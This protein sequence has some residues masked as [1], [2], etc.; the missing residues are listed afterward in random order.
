MKNEPYV[1][2]APLK[3]DPVLR[4]ERGWLDDLANDEHICFSL[5][6]ERYFLFPLGYHKYGFCTWKEASEG[7]G[8]PTHVFHS[9]DEVLDAK[10]FN[11]RSIRERL[12]EILVYDQA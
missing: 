4:T 9:E 11:G 5:D 12:G 7:G 3:C 10:L 8:Y 1:P 6:G 2:D